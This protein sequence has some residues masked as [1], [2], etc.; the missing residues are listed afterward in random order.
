VN[1]NATWSVSLESYY[2]Y[3]EPQEV[4]KA[5]T[6]SST[7][8]SLSISAKSRFGC[9]CSLGVNRKQNSMTSKSIIFMYL[10]VSK[11]RRYDESEDD[12]TTT[13]ILG[14]NNEGQMVNK[15]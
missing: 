11:K 7:Y 8:S 10:R 12:M 2:P 6:T 1:P 5:P 3:L 13:N 15:S 14:R 4:S 9:H